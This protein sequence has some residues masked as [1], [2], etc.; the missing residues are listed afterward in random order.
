MQTYSK[1]V[2]VILRW[3]VSFG[4]LSNPW[5]EGLFAETWDGDYHYTV[6]RGAGPSNR[7]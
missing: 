5:Y 3:A 2:F 1:A 7:P 4:R 6:G